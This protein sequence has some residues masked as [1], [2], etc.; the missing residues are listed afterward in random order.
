[1][2]LG[3]R[4]T[5]HGAKKQKMEDGLGENMSFILDTLNF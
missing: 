2:D 4:L 1:M 3:F 5:G